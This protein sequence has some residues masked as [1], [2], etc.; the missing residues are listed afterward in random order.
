MFV[1]EMGSWIVVL[2]TSLY[3]RYKCS[4][5]ETAL[6]AGGYNAVEGADDS[7]DMDDEG[8]TTTSPLTGIT[9]ANPA[10]KD[11]AP[12]HLRGWRIGLL[13][14]PTC[15]DITGTTLMNVGLLFVVASIYQMTR[16]ALVLFVGLFSVLFLRRHLYVYQWFALVTVVL[17]VGLVGLAGAIAQDPQ[18]SS[19]PAEGATATA[20]ATA[21]A[22]GQTVK[23][24]VRR[25]THTS[26]ALRATIGVGF[27]ASA[28]I[29]T[30]FQFV[31]EEWILERYELSPLE[32]VGWE[33]V[34]G[35]VATA[36]GMA[37]LHLAVGCTPAGRGGYFDAT[38]GLRAVVENRAVAVSSVLTMLSIGYVY[39]EYT[40]YVLSP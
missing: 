19:S 40:T 32:V 17:G 21:A 5:A 30:A 24:L 31:L 27:I 18:P 2:A 20:A 12:E 8:E 6:L 9:S 1:G 13:A 7:P 3:R 26:E 39:N 23:L 37:M 15:C 34:F 38:E 22:A 11:S 14:A 28:Q 29:F 16:G 33:G 35:F 10:I 36:V 4:R 25:A